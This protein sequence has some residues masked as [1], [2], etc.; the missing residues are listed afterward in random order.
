MQMERKGEEKG[1]NGNEKNMGR[2]GHPKR[3]SSTHSVAQRA[4]G[5]N[6]DSG[7]GGGSHFPNNFVGYSDLVYSGRR[8]RC[9][10]VGQIE[11]VQRGDRPAWSAGSAASLAAGSAAGAAAAARPISHVAAR[12]HQP[13]ISWR[14]QAYHCFH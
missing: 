1:A 6:H 3:N 4:A 14:D 11:R 10:I 13:S 5:R 9:S 2:H 12:L 7:G 8:K